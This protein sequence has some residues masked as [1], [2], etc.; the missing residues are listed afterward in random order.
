MVDRLDVLVRA[1][2]LAAEGDARA[3]EDVL[4]K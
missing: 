3:E 4:T 1:L 2:S